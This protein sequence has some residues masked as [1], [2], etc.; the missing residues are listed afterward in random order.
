FPSGVVAARAERIL[1]ICREFRPD[2]VL[3]DHH[4]LGLLGEMLPLFDAAIDERWR[5]RFVWGIPYSEGS[6]SSSH[7]PGNP[8]VARAVAH[9]DGV[10]ASLD[11]AG[12]E[13][14]SDRPA[15]AVPAR[16]TF[17]G[18]VVE[19]PLPPL[20]TELGPVVVACGGGEYA[21]HVC[22]MA[23]AAVALLPRQTPV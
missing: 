8:R 5:T 9:S 14:F 7:P 11:R 21:Q 3:V 19:P 17:V 4:P 6:I 13:V 22:E 12:S 20:P 2:A 16:H 18:T 15:W 23:V 10:S 1:D